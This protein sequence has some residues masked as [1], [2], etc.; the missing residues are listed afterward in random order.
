MRQ[1]DYTEEKTREKLVLHDFDEIK[2]IKEY[3]GINTETKNKKNVSI[4]QQIYKE[5]RNKLNSVVLPK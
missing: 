5:L 3:L 2:C 4:N 1:T